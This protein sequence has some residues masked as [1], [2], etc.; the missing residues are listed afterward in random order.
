MK[1]KQKLSAS[2]FFVFKN[3]LLDGRPARREPCD[4]NTQTPSAVSVF[5]WF[6]ILQ[7]S[8][9]GFRVSN[10]Y[11][12]Q[13]LKLFAVRRLF[14]LCGF[15]FQH[16]DLS[17]RYASYCWVIATFQELFNCNYL[18]G[19]L[20]AAFE[21]LSIRPFTDFANFFIFIHIICCLIFCQHALLS[22]SSLQNQ[23]RSAIYGFFSCLE[24][25][26][27]FHAHAVVLSHLRRKKSGLSLCCRRAKTFCAHRQVESE[28]CSNKSAAPNKKLKFIFDSNNKPV[29]AFGIKIKRF[30]NI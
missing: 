10:A 26:L 9:R 21:H 14:F 5:V 15:Y 23:N 20:I 27:Q 19:L 7:S 17:H 1:N 16:F 22:I 3:T 18:S 29:N 2:W 6:W 4:H 12:I 13:K 25:Y 28:Y 24:I 30:L 11:C 8:W